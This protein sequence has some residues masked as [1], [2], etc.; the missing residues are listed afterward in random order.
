[1]IVEVIAIG[2]ELLLGQ[3]VNTN[4]AHIGGRIA[5]LG[6]DSHFQQTVG[7]NL[8]RMKTSIQTAID[9]ADAVIITGGIGPTLDDITREAICAATGRTMHFS[10]EYA[11][12]LRERFASMGREMPESNL[13]QAEYPAGAELIPNP[14]G[15]APGLVLDHEE[16]LI[17][18]VPGVPAEMALLLETEVMPRIR[19]KA[20]ITSVLVSRVIRTW[21]QGE[22]SVGEQLADLY[23]ASTNPSV[24]FLASNG[25]I[26]IRLTAKAATTEEAE[27]LIA[28]VQAEVE[29]RLGSVIFGYDDDTIEEV[30]FRLAREKGW[31]IGTAE[32]ATAGMV[33]AR[34]TSVAGSS[35]VF[36]GSIGAY[37]TDLK[38]SILGVSDELI[39]GGAVNEA[40]ALAM[41]TGART[42]LGVDVAVSVTG[43][44]GPG[45][46]EE[47][48]GTMIIGVQTPEGSGVRTLRL[49]GD[50]ERVRSYATTA[51]LQLLRLGMTG[52][53]W[54]R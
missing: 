15:T 26:K 16:T 10:D 27:F 20:G 29:D 51:A 44:A 43:Y 6:V 36:R 3:I 33:S 54:D 37:A 8:D 17:F 49:P 13:R 48:P 19:A 53:W 9:R 42:V 30:L 21:G 14:R 4:L 28:P 1:M 52:T 41:A 22:A 7:D 39:N 38:H 2:T 34:L 25:E 47:P 23:V 18:A 46:G 5:E 24:A 50:R 35:D 31:S 12:A 45:G 40:T 32:S 11:E